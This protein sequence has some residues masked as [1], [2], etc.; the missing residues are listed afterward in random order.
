MGVPVRGISGIQQDRVDVWW[1][2][3]PVRG[4]SGIQQDRVDVWWMGVP[5]RGISGI[6]QDSHDPCME[7]YNTSLPGSSPGSLYSVQQQL[8]RPI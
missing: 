2:G 7:R 6:Q 8:G 5:V 1:M 4:I 3:V